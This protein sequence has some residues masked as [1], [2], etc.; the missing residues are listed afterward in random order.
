MKRKVRRKSRYRQLARRIGITS[1][2]TLIVLFLVWPYLRAGVLRLLVPVVTA[3]RGTLE[4]KVSGTA[5]FCG[6]TVI[7]RA[8]VSGTVKLVARDG[9]SVR[10]GDVVAEIENPSVSSDID[11]ALKAARDDLASYDRQT[12][13]EFDRYSKSLQT[14]YEAMVNNFIEIR[15]AFLANDF[16]SREAFE[17]KFQEWRDKLNS[18]RGTVNSMEQRRAD[19]VATVAF[20]EQ[21]RDASS[22]KVIAPS[23]G[24]F[25]T[26]LKT[27]EATLTPSQLSTRDASEILALSRE[28]STAG[29]MTV[30]NGQKVSAG[31]PVG[32]IVSG[33]QV[34]FYLP[35]KSEDQ[36][37]VKVGSRVEVQFDDGASFS[38][39][40]TGIS[41][42]KPPGYS[43]VTGVIPLMQPERVTVCSDISL[44]LKRQ[45]GVL[46]PQSSILEKDGQTGVLVVQK[47]Y[48]RF[49]PVEVLMEKDG[50]AIVKGISEGDEVVLRASR[51]L[52]GRRVR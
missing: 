26:R 32:K 5:V 36:P 48:A 44:I 23:S 39:S 7:L 46:V 12:K 35:L 45:S 14:A 16:R 43:V 41:S 51:L 19:L 20:L 30:K 22:V 40:I 4:E 2:V 28:L 47:T 18:Y 1:V 11:Q 27:G 24:L 25:A 34:T 3:A 38:G 21:A 13:D 17:S 31:E 6:G 9:E 10:V 52:E 15:R 33:E 50:K 37:L 29:T 8:P 42:G 49:Q